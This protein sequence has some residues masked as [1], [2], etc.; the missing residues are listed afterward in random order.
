MKPAKVNFN[1]IRSVFFFGLIILLLLTMLKLFKPFFYPIF[2]AAIIAVIFRPIYTGFVRWIKSP[3]A[4]SLLT[5]LIVIIIFFIPL[6]AVSLVV[7]NQS[8]ELFTRASSSDFMA[9]IQNVASWIKQ[10][11]IYP[12][13]YPVLEKWNENVS[14]LIRF[15]SEFLLNNITDLTKDSLRF[16]FM[17]FIMF[18]TLFFFF[19]D[20]PNILKKIMRLS[21]LGDGYEQMLYEKFTSAARAT[22]K[23]TLIVGLVQGTLGGILFWIAGVQGAIIWGL[24]MVIL[25]AIPGFGSAIIWLP[26]G[27]IMLLLGNVWQGVMI[28]I[29]GTLV[30]ST[31]DNII[32]PPLIGKDTQMHP[33]IVLFSTLGGL[34]VFGISGFVI[35]PIIASLFLSILSIYDFYYRRE[36]ENN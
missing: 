9:N 30:I 18:Y 4:S 34:V 19:K 3:T 22:L 5:I 16:I 2:W 33:L 27:I 10:T 14:N 32:R 8:K 26:T 25:S 31:I 15:V 23:T 29:F 1:V 17:F 24:I 13:I 28:L 6:T 36:L 35:G 7:V 12:Y 21:P 20:G 11:P